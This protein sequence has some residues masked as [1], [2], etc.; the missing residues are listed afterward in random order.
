MKQG[1]IIAGILS[2]LII[3]FALAMQTNTPE[4]TDGKAI[5]ITATIPPIAMIAEAIVGEN[6]SVHTILAPG[7]SPHTFEPTPQDIRRTGESSLIF[8][9]GHELDT[10]VTDISSATGDV[11]VVTVD[12]GI[13][14]ISYDDHAHDDVHLHGEHEDDHD[15][16]A[17][18][19]ESDAHGD[20]H[21]HG[22]YDPH[23]W[24][25]PDNAKRIAN[26]MRDALVAIDQSNEASYTAN[27]ES[28]IDELV[29]AEE[30]WQGTLAAITDSRI[31][32]FHDAWEYF[33][34]YADVTVAATVE[35][36]AGQQPTPQYL[37]QLQDTIQDTGVSALFT[38]PQLASDAV[39]AFISDTGVNYAILDPL[40]GVEGR[41]TYID[42]MTYNI[43]TLVSTLN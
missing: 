30:V 19:L 18:T 31:V 16:H 39:A 24:L 11:S 38:E 15:E 40:G 8:A 23:Y 21:L 28:F 13:E 2:L 37:A 32:T 36:F 42:L 10:W 6:G 20:E 3:V 43:D 33:A 1:Y 26:T 22:A 27:Y 17:D 12:Y 29:A 9:V 4:S 14:L 35:P 7:A 41:Q 25:S 5:Q 34:R